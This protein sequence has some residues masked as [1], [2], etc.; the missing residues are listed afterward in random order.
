MNFTLICQ[1]KNLISIA[2]GLF[3]IGLII[4]LHEFGHY[5]FARLFGVR[6]PSFSIGMGP[7][8]ISKKL[9]GTEFKISAIP[10][11][12]YVEIAGM[13][14]IGQGEQK[15]AKARDKGSFQSKAYWKKAI[16]LLGGILFNLIIGFILF[17]GLYLTGMPKSL[18]LNPQEIRPIIKKIIPDKPAAHAKLLE[19]DQI[20]AINNILI[21]NVLSLAQELQKN[22]SKDVFLTIKR[23][24]EEL[25]IP[26]KID[27]TGRLGIEFKTDFFPPTS[28]LTSIKKAFNTTINIMQ[29]TIEIFIRLFKKRTTEGV[30]G[31]LRLISQVI[32]NAKAGVSIFIFLLAF[33]SA[34]LAIINLIPL[35]ITDGGQ[36][37]LTT[38][39]AIIRRPLPEKI[40]EI[41]HTISWIL[42][43]AF[44]A[45][46]TFKD[47]K[48]LFWEKIKSLI[49]KIK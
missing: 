28:F 39:E 33:I 11:G 16:I 49:G 35:P 36:L 2:I 47:S 25:S 41:I 40:V 12:G 27:G 42:V 31:P 46:L 44:F 30:G 43:M 3:G 29:Q 23:N 10:L 5:L 1:L 26:V 7:K 19:G 13:A 6:A 24:N 48:M 9:W 34:Q 45:Y 8:L 32:S 17:V 21:S 38:I 20:I 4:G 18:L 22:I 37:L 14:E 15:E